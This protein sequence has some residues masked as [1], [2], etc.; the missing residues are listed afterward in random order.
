MKNCLNNK[1]KNVV[2]AG[3]ISL[4]AA[5]PA[6]AAV[7]ELALV[8]D[9][10][11][12]ISGSDFALQLDAYEDIFTNN[13]YDTYVVGN[14]TL[15]V[16]AWQFSTN[17]TQETLWYSITDNASA[18]AFGALFASINQDGGGTNIAS[19]I[20]D[21][22]A[23][24]IGNGIASDKQIIDISTDGEPTRCTPNCTGNTYMQSAINAATAALN[25]GTV[26]NAIGVGAGV[27]VSFLN[28]LTTAGGGFYETA[29]NFTAFEAAL[30][31]KL[32]REINQE[33][34]EPGTLALLS[35]GIIGLGA[36]RRKKVSA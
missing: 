25:Q 8:L 4:G 21:A 18:D 34:S 11:G 5:V 19:A 17:V 35:L 27:G 16:S 23:S 20:V 29:A 15:Y 30:S 9:G 13:F 31:Q 24:I 33:V 1:I 28:D 36:V 3:A 6:H 26:V 2:I 12:S 10:S 22:N 14:D 7:I 32:F